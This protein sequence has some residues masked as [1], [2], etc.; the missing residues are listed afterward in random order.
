MNLLKIYLI[1]S[2]AFLFAGCATSRITPVQAEV[3]PVEHVVQR[4]YELGVEKT[5]YVGDALAKLKDYYAQ[6]TTGAAVESTSDFTLEGRNLNGTGMH[7]MLTGKKGEKY[8]IKGTTIIE[9]KSYYTVQLPGKNVTLNSDIFNCTP[10]AL[11][12][13]STG[14][15]NVKG[16]FAN[17]YQT[18]GSGFSV[19]PNTVLLSKTSNESIS[20]EKGYINQELIYSGIAAGAIKLTYREYTK[21]D[22]ARPAFYQETSYELGAKTIRFKNIKIQV[23]E[24]TN[25]LI[26]FT[27][28]ED[29]L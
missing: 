29:G 9:G 20:S 7:V 16:I 25:E 18:L 8:P 12:D 28:L 4:S 24:A 26:R 5:A 19:N 11:V 21:D 1:A 23:H 27:V 10:C 22:M 17:G 6:K 15:P 13:V 14:I 2:T 3:S